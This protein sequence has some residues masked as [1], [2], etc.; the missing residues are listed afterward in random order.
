MPILLLFIFVTFFVSKDN[1]NPEET[2]APWTGDRPFSV[3]S[4]SSWFA[5]FD[6]TTACIH[7]RPAWKASLE[8][9]C[10]SSTAT[11]SNVDYIQGTV[12]LRVVQK[13]EQEP[14]D[15]VWFMLHKLGTL[16]GHQL[17][18]RQPE[19]QESQKTPTAA[20]GRMGRIYMGGTC[21]EGEASQDKEGYA[22]TS[23]EGKY[24]QRQEEAITVW[25]S[26]VGT[27]MEGYRCCASATTSLHSD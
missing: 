13:V 25:S 23:T 10:V 7:S 20:M 4:P 17:C 16:C 12:A 8:G 1:T 22:I 3:A 21:K 27:A 15:D 26:C 5:T 19:C 24:A 14:R 9:P 11:S 2:R 18:A 6:E